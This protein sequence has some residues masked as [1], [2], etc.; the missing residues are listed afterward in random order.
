VKDENIASRYLSLADSYERMAV[1][2]DALADEV[3]LVDLPPH[4]TNRIV[5]RGH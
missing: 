1:I 5:P 2:E 3:Q 4:I